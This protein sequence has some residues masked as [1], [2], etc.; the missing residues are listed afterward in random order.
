MAS[1][2][3]WLPRLQIQNLA[4][5]VSNAGHGL[6]PLV[7]V[8]PRRSKARARRM[9]SAVAAS[10][11]ER[12][13][14]QHIAHQRLARQ[15]VCQ[16]PG[17]AWCGSAQWTAP[18]A[19]GPLVPR[20]QSSRV[21]VPISRICGMPRPSPP[22]SQAVAPLNS[23]SELALALLPNL[24]FQALDVDGVEGARRARHAA[25]TGSSGP[26]AVCARIRNASHMGAEKN[27][28]C[29]VTV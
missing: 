23:T 22:T 25:G 11:L 20:A 8:R 2:A 16:R 5:G 19:S 21:M 17:V 27:H 7:H 15:A 24:C 14:G 3:K 10:D 29:P 18:G 1:C 4:T 13:V 9:A 12:Q 26:P 28:L 6:V